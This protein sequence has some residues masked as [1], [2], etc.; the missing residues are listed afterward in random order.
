MY[1]NECLYKDT[2]TIIQMMDDKMKNK[3]NANF[4][5]FLKKHQ[6][7]E[8]EGTINRNIPIREQNLREEVKLMLS[9]IYIDFFCEEEERRQILEKENENINAFYNKDIFKKKKSTEAKIE[10][11]NYPVVIKQ[12]RWHK[13]IA[14]IKQFFSRK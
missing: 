4:I 14:I 8:F 9:L 1:T 7:A 3:I 5:A 6:D 13:I 11:K 12:N 2:Y 10:Q